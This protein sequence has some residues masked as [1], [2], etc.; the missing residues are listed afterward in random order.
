MKEKKKRTVRSFENLEWLHEVRE[1]KHPLD[2]S[3]PIFLREVN[4]L[5]GD[6]RS[7]PTVPHPERHPYCE[8][9]IKFEGRTTQF[10]GGEKIERHRDIMFLGPNTPHYAYRHSY[11]HQTLTIYFLPL[12]LFE[13]GPNGGGSAVLSRFTASQTL[14]QR[15]ASPPSAIMRQITQG[16]RLMAQEWKVRPLCF[17]LKLWSLLVERLVELLRWEKEEGR[18]VINHAQP[19]DWPDVEKALRYIHDHFTELL[20]I[21]QIAAKVGTT[22]N[23]LRA[24]FRQALGTTCSHYIQSLRI[25]RAKSLL[26]L[27]EVQIAQV[28]YE[29]GFESISHFN[30]SFR[31]QVGLSPT[32]YIRNFR[33]PKI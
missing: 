22:T 28:A 7:Q 19:H 2:S 32:E 30:T 13:M 4:I 21:E 5:T 11:P 6:S 31:T 33:N 25:T 16:A 23:R 29:V 27:P 20:Y 18:Q 8:L 1:V 15:I 10:V 24:I 12:V 9:N 3:H 14:Q 17:E 26:C